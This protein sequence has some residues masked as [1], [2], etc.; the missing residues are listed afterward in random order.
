MS[1]SNQ[2]IR[3]YRIGATKVTCP[4]PF[5]PFLESWKLI[6]QK[7]PQARHC[8]LYEDDGVLN[9]SGEVEYKVHILPPKTNG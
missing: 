9:D 3:V 7:Y 4:F 6:I 1:I 2:T 8:T 5:L